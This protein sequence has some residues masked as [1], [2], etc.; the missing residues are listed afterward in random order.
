MG[1]GKSRTPSTYQSINPVADPDKIVDEA[2]L[3]YNR[4]LTVSGIKYLVSSEIII[5]SVQ[6]LVLMKW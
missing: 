4:N 6:V 3:D 5:G 2:V 1:L